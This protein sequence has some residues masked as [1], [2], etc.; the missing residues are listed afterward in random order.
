VRIGSRVAWGEQ[1]PAAR[2][3]RVGGVCVG[4]NGGGAVFLNNSRF[5]AIFRGTVCARMAHCITGAGV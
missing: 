4:K 5:F 2:P 1:V 3:G